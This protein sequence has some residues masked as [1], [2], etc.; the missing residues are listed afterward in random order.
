MTENDNKT[1]EMEIKHLQECYI[2]TIV[3]LT[4]ASNEFNR[5][6]ETTNE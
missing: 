1:L 6:Y 4:K 5:I 3:R 2:D